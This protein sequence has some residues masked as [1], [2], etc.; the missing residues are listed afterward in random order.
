M[1]QLQ[2]YFILTAGGILGITGIAKIISVFGT[3]LI[4]VQS[5]PL[6]GFSFRNLMLAA[7]AVELAVACLCIFT[8][9]P[10]RN[11]LLIAWLSTSFIIYRLWLWLLNWQRPCHCLGNLTDVLHISSQTADIAMK[12]VLGYLLIGSYT[13]LIWMWWRKPRLIALPF[14]E[15]AE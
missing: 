14:G 9:Q 3:Q 8:K 4:L 7:G 1:S 6:F 10:K 15:R 5:D 2:R 12:I 13:A 11:T